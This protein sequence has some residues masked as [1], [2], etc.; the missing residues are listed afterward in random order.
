MQL[1]RVTLALACLLLAVDATIVLTTTGTVATGAAVGA[2][3]R[4]GIGGL[5]LGA[6]LVGAIAGGGRR[7]GR[8]RGRRAAEAADPAREL[9]LEVSA[10][11]DTA[12]CALKLVCL[13]EAEPAGQ[14]GEEAGRLLRLVGEPELPAEVRTPR[15]AYR[16]A[17]YLGSVG[18]AAACGQQ[19]PVCPY[20]LGDMM[21]Y[22]RRIAA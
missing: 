8:G 6:G 16:Y 9:A 15:Q 13:L 17:A 4:A 18:G 10:A 3:A 20:G 11:A 1:S 14:R 2:A 21:A 12:G 19:F 7:R 22:V 5:A